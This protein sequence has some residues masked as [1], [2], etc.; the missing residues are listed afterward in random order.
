MTN[1]AKFWTK[2]EKRN[3]GCW[4]HTNATGSHGYAQ[5]GRAGLAHRVAWELTHGPIPDGA[6]VLHRCNVKRCV[7]PSHLYLGTHR[8]NMDDVARAKNHPKRKLSTEQVAEIRSGKFSARE[9]ARRY[10]VTQRAIQNA[11]DGI[12]Y[13]FD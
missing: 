8:E 11:R 9:L 10:G 3:D 6:M 1:A 13:R 2:I 4:I 7:N 12:T 5:Y